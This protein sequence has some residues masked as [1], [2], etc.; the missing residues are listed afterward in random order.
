MA[1]NAGSK[2][3]ALEA[4]DFIINVLKDHEQNLDK[5]IA[6]LATVAEQISDTNVGLKSKVEGAEEKINN[7]QKEVTN[8]ISYLSDPPKALALINEQ[9]PQIGPL[10]FPLAFQGQSSL[11]FRCTK[12]EDFR[13]LAM[14]AQMLFFNYKEDFKAFEAEALIENQLIKYAGAI[15]NFSIVLKTWLSQQLNIID[16]SIMEGSLYKLK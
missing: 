6:E 11:I 4:L 2:D 1:G 9:K 14:N 16:H 15:P 7:L 10:S 3:K 13:S 8:L 12:W 5:S